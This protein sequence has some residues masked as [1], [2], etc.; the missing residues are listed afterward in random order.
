MTTPIDH[1]EK[2][3]WIEIIPYDP[4][5]KI[6]GVEVFRSFIA[7]EGRQEGLTQ[8]WTMQIESAG[9]LD[10]Q[11]DPR[12][13]KKINWPEEI[14]ECSLST[15]K[16]YDTTVLRTRYSSLTTPMTWQASMS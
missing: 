7:I 12:M 13:L 3:N 1:S 15:N 10:H 2:E 8:L 9:N 14:Y 5:R 16:V 11:V 6:D 4:T